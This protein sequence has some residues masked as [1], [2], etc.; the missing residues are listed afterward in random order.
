[1]PCVQSF[2]DWEH[3]T[4]IGDSGQLKTKSLNV[5]VSLGIFIENMAVPLRWPARTIASITSIFYPGEW[6]TEKRK[7]LYRYYNTSIDKWMA[8]RKT[9][10]LANCLERRD[11]IHRQNNSRK[12]PW[13]CYS[14]IKFSPLRIWSGTFNT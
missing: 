9:S 10:G 3:C 14:S 1:M 2:Q 6:N 13:S 11:L 5:N 12:N 7:R 4:Q 8:L